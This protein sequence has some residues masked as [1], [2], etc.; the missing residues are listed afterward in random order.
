MALPAEQ[1]GQ[2]Q[3]ELMRDQRQE[4]M[5]AREQVQAAFDQASRQINADTQQRNAEIQQR[6]QALTQPGTASNPIYIAPSY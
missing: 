5:V 2:A 6:M 3:I 1:Q 4:Q